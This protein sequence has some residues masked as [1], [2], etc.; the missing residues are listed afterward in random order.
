M[1]HI[2]L[3]E[4]FHTE[5]SNAYGAIQI[6][7]GDDK[8]TTSGKCGVRASFERDEF[9]GDVKAGLFLIILNNS[10]EC[11]LKILKTVTV[12]NIYPGKPLP[13]LLLQNL[14]ANY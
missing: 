7:T 8:K 13:C 11:R 12:F 2:Y 9:P 14:S 5:A 1:D 6:E 10:L 3:R 4:L